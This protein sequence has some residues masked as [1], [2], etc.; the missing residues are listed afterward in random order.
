MN[1]L[2]RQF[3]MSQF[4]TLA[5]TLAGCVSLVCAVLAFAAMSWSTRHCYRLVYLAIG[6]AGLCLTL[7]P[8]FPD[9]YA[10]LAPWARALFMMAFSAY[11]VL[12]R[13]RIGHNRK[14]SA[15]PIA[16]PKAAEAAPYDPDR[17]VPNEI[18]PGAAA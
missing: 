3:D 2:L 1:E 8:L 13:R 4:L 9:D 7:G 12:D 15:A 6:L 5:D 18:G 14:P 16:G 11:M 10:L 17:T